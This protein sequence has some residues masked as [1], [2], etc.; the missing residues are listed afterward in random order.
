MDKIF[1][2]LQFPSEMKKQMAGFE[3]IR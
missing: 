2:K 3:V 1:R